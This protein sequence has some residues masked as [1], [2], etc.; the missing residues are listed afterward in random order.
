MEYNPESHNAVFARIEQKLDSIQD[1]IKEVKENNTRL[2]QKM[3][4][5]DIIQE[6]LKE[7]KE[8]SVKLTERVST[9]EHFKYYLIGAT[10]LISSLA[11]YFLNKVFGKDS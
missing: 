8:S 11:V 1:S 6:S 2:S 9:L 5:I 10:S 3:V 4:S 7:I